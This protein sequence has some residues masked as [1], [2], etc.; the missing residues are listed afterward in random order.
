MGFDFVHVWFS[1]SVF[2][3][4]LVYVRDISSN[5]PVMHACAFPDRGQSPGCRGRPSYS[6]EDRVRRGRVE[7]QRQERQSS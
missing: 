2:D 5:A 7:R 1:L 3:T 6:S 4:E